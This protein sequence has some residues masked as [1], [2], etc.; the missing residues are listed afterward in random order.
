MIAIRDF[1]GLCQNTYIK[2]VLKRFQMYDCKPIDTTV[3]KGE[4]LCQDISP[5]TQDDIKKMACVPS[6]SIVG[7]L[8]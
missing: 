3:S 5:M 2:K 8:I 1:L 7:R 6:A 4:N